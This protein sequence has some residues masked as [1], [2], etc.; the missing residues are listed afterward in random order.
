MS[1]HLEKIS[2]KPL[3]LRAAVFNAPGE[4]DVRRCSFAGLKKGE[5]LVSI[6]ACG[7]CGS[8][9]NI[10]HRNPPVPVYWAGHEISGVVEELGPGVKGLKKGMRVCIAPLVPC[11]KCVQC[12]SGRDNLCGRSTFVSFN[13]PGG[14]A[15]MVSLPAS[16]VFE[17]PAVLSF[18]E[19]VLIEPFADALHAISVAGN[20]AGKRALVIGCGTL[21]LLTIKALSLAGVAYVAVL[22]RYP[23]QRDHAVSMGADNALDP[24][25]AAG[26]LRDDGP[27]D[28]VFETAGGFGSDSITLSIDALER[29]GII[30][31]SGVHYHT[32]RMNLKDLTEKEIQIR[33]AQRYR[34]KD[35]V[36]A[37]SLFAEGKV[38]AEGLITHRVALERIM[39]GFEIAFHKKESKAIK[40]VVCPEM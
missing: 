5:V 23:Y 20:V 21:G 8:D 1:M 4:L 2:E 6:N 17:I 16:N 7:I 28:V 37:L 12:R 10:F 33:G 39:D 31:L 18:G 25:F 38:E 13:R 15:N 9:L 30:V 32:P 34:K 26:I 19:A 36:K 3:E 11:Q 24:E 40:V 14:F 29:S 35:F 22:G 27:F